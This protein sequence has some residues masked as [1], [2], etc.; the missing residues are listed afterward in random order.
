MLMTCRR[1]LR[2]FPSR[3]HSTLRVE[4]I[5]QKARNTRKMVPHC[6]VMQFAI[7]GPVEIHGPTLQLVSWP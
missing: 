1:S 2:R 6:Q 7:A 4:V 5:N 3:N